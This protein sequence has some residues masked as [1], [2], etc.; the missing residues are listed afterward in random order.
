[1]KITYKSK[2]GRLSVELEGKQKD[3]FQDVSSFQEI[4]EHDQ[5]GSCG[6]DNIRFV[7]R[8]VDDNDFYEIQCQDRSCRARLAL[9]QHKGEKGT[10]FPRL[11]SPEG[12]WL[13]NNGWTKWVPKS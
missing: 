3:V 12:D 2:N 11:K 10:L 13:E 7:V 9:G 8:N 6:T 1:M 5:C 4:F